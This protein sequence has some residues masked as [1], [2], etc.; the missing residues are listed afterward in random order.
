ML[1]YSAKASIKVTC[2][3]VCTNSNAHA[4]SSALLV[5]LRFHTHCALWERNR[6]HLII[7]RY[8]LKEALTHSTNWVKYTYKAYQFTISVPAPLK[9]RCT[10]IVT[11]KSFLHQDECLFR[12]IDLPLMWYVQPQASTW[13]YACIFITVASMDFYKIN[14][15]YLVS[16][17]SNSSWYKLALF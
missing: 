10:T 16:L 12:C 14:S 7:L 1:T 6:P 17:R 11:K 5:P 8:S 4:L 3:V 9:C 15:S 2:N 13:S